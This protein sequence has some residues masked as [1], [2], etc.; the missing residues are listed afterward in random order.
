M[1]PL[2]GFTTLRLI[3]CFPTVGVTGGFL[4]GLQP[5][6]QALPVQALTF[7]DH[8]AFESKRKLKFRGAPVQVPLTVTVP[9]T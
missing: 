3:T 7:L 2:L 1:A 6:S 4:Y 5:V 9:R 8:S